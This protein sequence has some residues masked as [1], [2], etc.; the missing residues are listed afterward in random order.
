MLLGLTVALASPGAWAASSMRW[1]PGSPSSQALLSRRNCTSSSVSWVSFPLYPPCRHQG[2]PELCPPRSTEDWA[3]W[4]ALFVDFAVE[5]LQYKLL[6]VP[7][8]QGLLQKRHG[9]V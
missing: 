4:E 5:P 9:Q 3:G 1:P 6:T 2:S 8:L 7:I